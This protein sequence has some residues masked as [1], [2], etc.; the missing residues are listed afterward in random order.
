VAV[1]FKIA[2]DGSEI[3]FYIAAVRQTEIVV[4]V[5]GF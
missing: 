2:L 4:A 3:A 5:Q 1:K